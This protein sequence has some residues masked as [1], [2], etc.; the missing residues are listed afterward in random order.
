MI[1]IS[2][3]LHKLRLTH[4]I[5]KIV[6]NMRRGFEPKPEPWLQI[7]FKKKK[8][9]LGPRANFILAVKTWTEKQKKIPNAITLTAQAKILAIKKQ[10]HWRMLNV[11][12]WP[13]HFHDKK[14]PV[15]LLFFWRYD[16]VMKQ[17]KN[18]SQ[19]WQNE[20]KIGQ[21]LSKWHARLEKQNKTIIGSKQVFSVL[22]Q[23][24]VHFLFQ[25][26]K[27]RKIYG[28][29]GGKQIWCFDITNKI[30]GGSKFDKIWL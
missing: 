14:K 20:S 22:D 19:L 28:K 5:V 17:I 2:K 4:A 26:L 18:M 10:I 9:F 8:L 16:V 11:Y 29:I 25:L 3:I 21:V 23:W 7:W 24:K 15:H 27:L 30:H 6:L 13:P 12:K 1:Q